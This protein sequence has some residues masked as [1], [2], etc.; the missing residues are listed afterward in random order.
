MFIFFFATLRSGFFLLVRFRLWAPPV[1]FSFFF[2]SPP[3][4]FVRAPLIFS[5]SARG[6]R[7]M[8]DGTTAGIGCRAP[9]MT[10]VVR[11]GLEESRGLFIEGLY[12]APGRDRAA[13]GARRAEL[14]IRS[15]R[16]ICL[17]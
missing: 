4:I 1:F 9:G 12:F 7:A 5:R 10:N 16:R 11:Y 8:K 3:R 13:K 2:F 17:D 6:S 14:S 15:T